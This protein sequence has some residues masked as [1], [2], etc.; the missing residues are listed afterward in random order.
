MKKILRSF[1]EY[2]TY[3]NFK[4]YFK[5][6]IIFVIF[7]ASVVFNI[8][9]CTTLFTPFDSAALHMNTAVIQ[10]KKETFNAYIDEKVFGHS[11]PILK[12][13]PSHRGPFVWREL[14]NYSSSNPVV[15]TYDQTTFDNEFKGIHPL[16]R[17]LLNEHLNDI[18]RLE[19]KV[20][21]IDID[22]SPLKFPTDQYKSC[23]SAL[24]QTLDRFASKIV[25][26]HPVHDTAMALDDIT[27]QWM[28]ERQKNGVSFANPKLESSLGI[29]INRSSY[30]N[31][32]GSI[33]ANKFKAMSEH[34]EVSF[35][36]KHEYKSPIN[37]IQ[38]GNFTVLKA[39]QKATLKNRAVFLGGTFGI[40]DYYLTPLNDK[41]PGV[42]IHAYDYYSILNPIEI[43][44]IAGIIALIGDIVFAIFVGFLMMPV[45]KSYIKSVE[46][47]KTKSIAFFAFPFMI[48]PLL[49][50]FS[51][52]G[53]SAS[54][55]MLTQSIWISP[56][57]ILIAIFIDG[58][59]SK[60]MDE[61]IH[62]D[63]AEKKSTNYFKQC[64]AWL[65]Q[66][67]ASTIGY[68]LSCSIKPIV[69]I[70][71]VIYAIYLIWQSFN[72]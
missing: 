21:T 68:R 12:D 58:L 13:A 62:E 2:F 25:L 43:H 42:I 14:P 57:P 5:D 7:L 16:D 32:M 70:G 26:I 41:V 33:T 64:K 17:C 67:K 53:L 15:L 8:H 50:F 59:L 44:G 1:I 47:D 27:Q 49:I 40:D 46:T 52:I 63:K 19:P 39:D 56:I 9:H 30:V 38:A 51:I 54:A 45:W 69:M 37:F 60:L 3:E 31:S 10:P 71:T 65:E 55:F 28:E 61:A 24:N 18:F 11:Q 23:Q 6:E 4:Q 29:V 36:A 48:L 34:E 72:H 20:V 66:C 35:N 22:L